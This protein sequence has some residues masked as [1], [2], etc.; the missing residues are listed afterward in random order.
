MQEKLGKVRPRTIG[1]ASRIPGVTPAAVSLV[2]VYIEIQA[3]RREQA[4][5]I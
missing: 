3:R 5:A 1:Q 4:A 2:N